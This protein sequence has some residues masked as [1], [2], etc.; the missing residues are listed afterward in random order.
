VAF[1][2]L[3]LHSWKKNLDTVDGP[4]RLTPTVH[5]QS[6]GVISWT[7]AEYGDT[8]VV[9]DHM[10]GPKALPR[11]VGKTL[12]A[13]PVAHVRRDPDGFHTLAL[14][15]AHGAVQ[16][17]A[18]DV[19]ENH[20]GTFSA[21]DARDGQADA[22][23]AACDDRYP[24]PKISHGPFLEDHGERSGGAYASSRRLSTS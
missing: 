21:E 17:A 24:I 12:D 16:S 14:E 22:A 4:Q 7:G 15:K 6:S 23:R 1:L 13:R 3:G 10:G 19:R 8:G 2:A 5:F 9:H 11:G 18:F 20:L